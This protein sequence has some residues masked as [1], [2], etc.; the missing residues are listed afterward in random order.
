MAVSVLALGGCGGVQFEGRAFEAI[1]LGSKPE[2]VDSKMKDRAPLIIPPSPQL[3][4]PGPREQ[5]AK[6]EN[7]PENPE[8]KAKRQVAEAEAKKEE[9]Y[10]RGNWG[11]DRDIDDFDKLFDERERRPGVFGG[12]PLGDQYRGEDPHG[13]GEGQAR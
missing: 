3:P 6:P 10:D 12:G 4:A 9:Y 11:K 2:T 7:W 8:D 13:E 5:I 1:G